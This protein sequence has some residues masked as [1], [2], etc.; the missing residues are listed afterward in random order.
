MHEKCQCSTIAGLEA[1]EM[2]SMSFIDFAE[3]KAAALVFPVLL[4]ACCLFRF[5]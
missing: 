2:T 1:A 3:V 4:V 5:P